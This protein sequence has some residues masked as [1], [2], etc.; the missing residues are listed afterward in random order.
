MTADAWVRPN[1]PW[2]F[3][4]A[5]KVRSPLVASSIEA[6]RTISMSPSPSRRHPRRS[7]MSF[8]LKERGAP[9]VQGNRGCICKTPA[10]NP[11]IA[12][13]RMPPLDVFYRIMLS[14]GLGAVMGIEREIRRKPAGLRTNILICLGSALF[15]S[16]SIHMGDPVHTP[17]RIAAQIVTGIGFL[18]AG[19]ILRARGTVHGMTTAATIWVNAGVGMAVGA[20]QYLA[21]TIATASTI[22]VLAILGPIEGYFEQR[23]KRVG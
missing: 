21:A 14:A 4:L 22:V 1:Q 11:N 12:A 6:T 13:E 19:T 5:T 17:D 2:Y 15:T 9:G 3:E 20:G 10:S 16:V 7:A 18:G 8:N 23:G